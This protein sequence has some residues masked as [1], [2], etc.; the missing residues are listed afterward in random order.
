MYQTVGTNATVVISQA[1]D[2][3]IYRR[4]ITGSPK[5]KSLDYVKE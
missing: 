4:A 3:P 2:K 1:L 5:V